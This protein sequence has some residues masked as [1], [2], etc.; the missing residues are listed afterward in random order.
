[1]S[2][3]WPEMHLAIIYITIAKLILIIYHQPCIRSSGKQAVLIQMPYLR[4]T[5]CVT[6]VQV[7]LQKAL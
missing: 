5:I 3:S 6:D 4:L 7:K 1:M 2:D